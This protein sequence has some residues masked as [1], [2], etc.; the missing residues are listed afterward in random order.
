[1]E[2]TAKEKH[3]DA[4]ADEDSFPASEQVYGKT[5]GG[6]AIIERERLARIASGE[7]CQQIK[8]TT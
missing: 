8:L 2:P 1:M 5:V 7:E 4:N 6:A 3:H